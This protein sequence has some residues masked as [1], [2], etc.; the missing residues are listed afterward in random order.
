MF[1]QEFLS[2]DL[3]DLKIFKFLNVQATCILYIIQPW[4]Q[5]LV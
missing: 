4:G 3:I 5:I 2:H 1:I